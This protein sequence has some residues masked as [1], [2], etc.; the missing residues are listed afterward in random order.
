MAVCLYEGVSSRVPIE[1]PGNDAAGHDVTCPFDQS[2]FS[3]ECL[4]IPIRAGN[5]RKSLPKPGES[6]L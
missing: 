1:R 4:L 6:W 5:H 2:L 3:K